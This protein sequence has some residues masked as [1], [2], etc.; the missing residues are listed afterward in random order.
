MVTSW[1]RVAAVVV[2]A[3]LAAGCGIVGGGTTLK[4][5]YPWADGL[6]L[7]GIG[8]DDGRAMRLSDIN[9]CTDGD[10]PVT[11]TGVRMVGPDAPKVVAYRVSH[12][13]YADASGGSLRISRNPPSP[14][15][16]AKTRS[17]PFAQVCSAKNDAGR[18]YLTIDAVIGTLP[19]EVE[20]LDVRYLTG[21]EKHVARLDVPVVVCGPASGCPP[22]P[23]DDGF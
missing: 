11:V 23:Y 20:G 8:A 9:V 4:A 19:V 2:A 21:G 15:G 16:D 14:P 22:D 1:S 12:E 10:E 6:R 18:T 7:D 3:G 17:A 13:Q 5:G